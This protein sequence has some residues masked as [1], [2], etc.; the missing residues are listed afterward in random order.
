MKD[1]YENAKRYYFD[2]YRYDVSN[3]YI[4]MRIGQCFVF[5]QNENDAKEYL[6]RAYL[7]AGEDVFRGNEPFLDIIKDIIEN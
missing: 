2:A 1:D 7:M 5:L 4:N 6:M 3:P